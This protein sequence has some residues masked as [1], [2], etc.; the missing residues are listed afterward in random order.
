[1]CHGRKLPPVCR[2][3]WP[4]NY[5]TTMPSWLVVCRCVSLAFF[6]HCCCFNTCLR[7]FLSLSIV[8]L[9][10][11]CRQLARQFS[12]WPFCPDDPFP[13]VQEGW[14]LHNHRIP[15]L[16]FVL[17]FSPRQSQGLDQGSVFKTYTVSS[18]GGHEHVLRGQEKSGLMDQTNCLK[19]R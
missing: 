18:L 12:P 14:P 3:G 11:K 2:I 9:G 5:G 19:K 8:C 17:F 13:S 15:K 4:C 16:G 10:V 7:L 6:Q 1:M